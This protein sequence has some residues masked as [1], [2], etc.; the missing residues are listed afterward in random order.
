[1][2]NKKFTIFHWIWLWG[3]LTLMFAWLTDTTKSSLTFWA[4]MFT[5][6][7]L[8][9]TVVAYFVKVGIKKRNIKNIWACYLIPR[10]IYNSKV[11]YEN[12][13]DKENFPRKLIVGIGL[14]TI[15]IQ[16]RTKIDIT[17]D[18]ILVSF[19]GNELNKPV[20]VEFDTQFI[21]EPLSNGRYR[22]WHGD[23]HPKVPDYPRP[24]Y[25]QDCLMYE[26][27]VR[28]CGQWKGKMIV[29]IPARE[30]GKQERLLDFSVSI[31]SDNIPFLIVSETAKLI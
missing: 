16:I 11:K 1:M 30:F 26:Y 19:R 17:V 24:L 12:A 14:H 2:F 6:A 5:A 28:T 10:K 3:L 13:P 21:S 7:V 23:I 15:F 27:K 20:I 8:L 29:E 25:H 9:V 18:R 4:T 22:D 31:N